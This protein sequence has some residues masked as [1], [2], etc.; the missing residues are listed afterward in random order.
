MVSNQLMG[1]SSPDAYFLGKGHENR[2]IASC[3]LVQVDVGD[4]VGV[5][6]SMAEGCVIVPL[7]RSAEPDQTFLKSERM[8]GGA[9]LSKRG[10]TYPEAQ[11]RSFQKLDRSLLGPSHRS[12][13]SCRKRR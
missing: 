11:G 6:T 8:L 12:R 1:G 7:M 2:E 13:Q 4:V 9:Q 3:I 10:C 5:G